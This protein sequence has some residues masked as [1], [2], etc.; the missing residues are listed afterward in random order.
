MIVT[1]RIVSLSTSRS[2]TSPLMCGIGLATV[3]DLNDV[4]LIA[5]V[6]QQVE[7]AL[8]T[9]RVEQVAEHDGQPPALAAVDEVLHHPRQVG[10]PA[11]RLEPLEELEHG[12]DP[13]LAARQ[14]EV[15][16]DVAGEGDH[17]HAVQVGQRDVP[18]RRGDL[19]GIVELDGSPKAMLREQSSSR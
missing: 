18:Q 2:S 3:A 10:H 1:F 9:S 5:V 12:Q 7:P 19:P 14:R 11:L 16:H 6:P 4:R 15:G 8:I 13:P 17:G